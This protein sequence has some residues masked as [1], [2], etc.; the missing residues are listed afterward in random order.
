MFWILMEIY[1]KKWR[2]SELGLSGKAELC[3][4]ILM[5]TTH[6]HQRE[7]IIH[8]WGLPALFLTTRDSLNVKINHLLRWKCLAVCLPPCS[9]ILV[10]AQLIC[11]EH[12]INPCCRLNCQIPLKITYWL[13]CW[14]ESKSTASSLCFYYLSSCSY[15][16]FFENFFHFFYGRLYGKYPSVQ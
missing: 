6:V 10:F 11:R 4:F 8:H 13:R 9:L 7:D 12:P 3:T 1:W 5:E 16:W 15:L 14:G 2:I